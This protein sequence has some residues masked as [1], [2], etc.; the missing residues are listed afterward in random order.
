MRHK[1]IDSSTTTLPLSNAHLILVGEEKLAIWGGY[2]VI[3]RG[4]KKRSF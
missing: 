3:E 1:E 4:S 2:G